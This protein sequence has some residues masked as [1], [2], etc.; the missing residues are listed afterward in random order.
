MCRYIYYAPPCGKVVIKRHKNYTKLQV[1]Y[2]IKE[3][4]WIPKNQ[5]PFHKIS[6]NLPPVPQVLPFPHEPREPYCDVI[7]P[8]D[9]S[10]SFTLAFK[11]LFKWI[12]LFLKY[13]YTHWSTMALFRELYCVTML[14]LCTNLQCVDVITFLS[15]VGQFHSEG[16]CTLL[17]P[18]LLVYFPNHFNLTCLLSCSCI[19]ETQYMVRLLAEY[20]FMIL[21]LSSLVTLASFWEVKNLRH[22]CRRFAQNISPFS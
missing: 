18:L 14:N 6:L 11:A 8:C 3:L 17:K 16:T 13:M 15:A 20:S 4:M 2:Q 5:D 1:A 19:F 22:G 7:N 9:C 21:R 12:R 10:M